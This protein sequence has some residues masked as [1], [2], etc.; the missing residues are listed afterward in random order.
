MSAV[1][2]SNRTP[3]LLARWSGL[4]AAIVIGS[5]ALAAVVPT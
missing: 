4:P 3:W 1:E 5:A 2:R